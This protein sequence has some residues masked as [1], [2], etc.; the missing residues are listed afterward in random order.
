MDEAEKVTLTQSEIDALVE[1]FGVRPG[2]VWNITAVECIIAARLAPVRAIADGIAH[3]QVGKFIAADI[4]EA[5][6]LPL[7]VGGE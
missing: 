6:S 4:Y 1:A 2:Q 3:T 7:G 5:L